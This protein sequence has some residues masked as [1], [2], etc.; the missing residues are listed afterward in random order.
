M[1]Y[2][3]DI[4]AG[5]LKVPESRVI[6]DL[7][8]QG[9]D[10]PEWDSAVFAENRLQARNPATARRLA[11]LIQNRLEPMGE[12]LW[13]LVR[14]GTSVVAAQACMAAAIKQS[15]LLGDFMDLVVREQYRLFSPVLPLT[16]WET[17]LQDCHG[18][19]PEMPEWQA[20]TLRRLRSSV[21]Q[22]LAQAG[23]LD[24]TRSRHLQTVHVDRGVLAYLKNHNES[25]VLR[26]MDICP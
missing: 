6:A 22:M 24:N 20:P 4:T 13:L 1:R 9:A 7:L 25:Y 23:Y 17:Y 26:C 12:D 21:Y 16:V 19:D 11:R 14:D 2:R 8:L 3:A 18:R 15:P 5:A 10:K